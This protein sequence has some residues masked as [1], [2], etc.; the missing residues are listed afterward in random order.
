LESLANV[1]KYA[2]AAHVRIQVTEAGQRLRVRV[3]DDGPGGADPGRGSGLRGLADRVEALGGRL[4]VRSPAGR[5]TTVEAQLPLTRTP[6][7]AVA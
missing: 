4:S 1:A 7:G 6:H 2:P 3:T 5:G